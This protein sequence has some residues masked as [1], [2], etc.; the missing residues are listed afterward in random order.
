MSVSGKGLHEWVAVTLCD[1]GDPLKTMPIRDHSLEA[2]MNAFKGL[3]R[4]YGKCGRCW[5]ETR[6]GEIINDTV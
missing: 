6:E 4:T 3:S 2:A 5:Q 1:F